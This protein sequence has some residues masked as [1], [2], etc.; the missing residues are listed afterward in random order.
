MVRRMEADVP[1]ARI[2]EVT[3]VYRRHDDATSAD[4][5]VTKFHMMSVFRELLRRRREAGG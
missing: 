5:R 3:L 1:T 4:P 2:P